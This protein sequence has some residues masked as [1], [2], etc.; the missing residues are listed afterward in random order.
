M[1]LHSIVRGAITSVARD[2]PCDLLTMTG[3]QQRGERGDLLPVFNRPVQVKAQWQS[4]KSDEIVLSEK[5][6]SA[7]IVRKV[8][9]YAEDDAATLPWAMWR[10]LGRSG[11]LL[12]DDKGNYWLVDAVIEDFTHEGWV[13]VQAILQTSKPRFV[14]KEVDDAEGQ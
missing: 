4:L 2:L 3:E 9:L 1:N 6:E 14:L 12:Q 5:I 10:P 13:C 11:D 7:S 8:Y